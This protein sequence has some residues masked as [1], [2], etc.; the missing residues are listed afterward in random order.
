MDQKQRC[1]WCN[2]SNPLYVQYHDEEWGVANFDDAYLYEMLILESFQ[3]GLSWECVLN[4]RAHFRQAYRNFLLEKVASFDEETMAQLQQ[5]PRIIRNRLKIRASVTNSRIFQ[6]I[7]SEYGSFYAYLCTFTQ[8]R[9]FRETGRTT[10]PLSDAISRDLQARGM[11]FMG[12]VIVY[13]YLQAI[14]IIDAHEEG[15]FLHVPGDM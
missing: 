15:C 2:P 1:S 7:V 6:G 9:R 5:D 12:S 8:G 14:G 3:A 4:K 10:S 11:K 13:A